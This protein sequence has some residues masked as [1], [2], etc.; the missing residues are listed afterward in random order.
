MIQGCQILILFCYPHRWTFPYWRHL[1]ITGDHKLTAGDHKRT[2]GD[3]KLT[4]RDHIWT[5]PAVKSIFQSRCETSNV[6]FIRLSN[7][8]S[9]A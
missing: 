6:K 1:R 8:W 7:S 9:L 4:A 3:H 2:A 5:R